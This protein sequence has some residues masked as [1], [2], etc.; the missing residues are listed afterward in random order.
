MLTVITNKN[1]LKKF[2]KRARKRVKKDF[3]DNLISQKLLEFIDAR[4]N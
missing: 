4:I 3:D 1:L 2:G